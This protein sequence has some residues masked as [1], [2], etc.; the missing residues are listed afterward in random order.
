MHQISI[1]FNYNSTIPS[2]LAMFS[3][4]EPSQLV[5]SCTQA[6]HDADSRQESLLASNLGLGDISRGS[7][8]LWPR[9]RHW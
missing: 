8:G 6:F 9:T 1:Y 4:A 5:P 3:S 2:Y 7:E